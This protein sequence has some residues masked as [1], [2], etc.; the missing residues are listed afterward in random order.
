MFLRRH[1]WLL[2][3]LLAFGGQAH[4]QFGSPNA[5]TAEEKAQGW[6]LLFDGAAATG[7]RGL[8]KPDFLK[9]GWSIVRG[10]LYL[11][12]DFKD[13]GKVTGGDLVS[14]EQFEDFEFS[15]EWKLSVAANT[16]VRYLARRGAGGVAT[17]M[18]YQIIDDVHHPEGLKGGPIRRTGALD[19]I[20]PPID[21]KRLQ[22]AGEWNR[23]RI[24]LQGAHVEHWLNGQKV[25][26]FD[27]GSR[28]LTAAAQAAKAKVQPGFGTKFKSPVV[29]L[30]QGDEVSF[31][32]LK[33]RALPRLPAVP[34]TSPVPATPASVIPKGAPT[35]PAARPAVASPPTAPNL[36]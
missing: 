32:A 34:V 15:F 28:A 22:D 11:A 17:G 25:V 10:E 23:G 1:L 6:K 24:V 8:Q 3:A 2:G 16:G 27:L 30:D 9:A 4:G 5:L 31:R 14:T 18:E 33:I 21:N 36:R 35:T 29:L 13:M 26:E 20:L 7:L 19:G 12:K